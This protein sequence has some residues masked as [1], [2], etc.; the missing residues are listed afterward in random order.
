MA[1]LDDATLD[2]LRDAL[3]EVEEKKADTEANGGD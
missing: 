1:G 2:D 3:A